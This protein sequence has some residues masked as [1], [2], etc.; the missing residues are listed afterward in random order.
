MTVH[1]PGIGAIDLAP[2]QFTARAVYRAPRR[3]RLES[4][5]RLWRINFLPAVLAGKQIALCNA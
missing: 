3:A 1:S 5:G 4:L 2:R